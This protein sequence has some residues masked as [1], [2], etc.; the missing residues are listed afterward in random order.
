MPLLCAQPPCLGS[1]LLLNGLLCIVWCR[2]AH[3]RLIDRSINDA[4]RLVTGCLQPTPT[5]N[6]CVL[7]GIQISELRRKRVTLSLARDAQDPKHILYE[8]L[9]Y[10]PYGGHRQLKFRRLFVPAAIDLLN[11]IDVLSTNAAGS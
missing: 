6:L 9:L 5:D 11:D 7:A 1:I 2:S 4:L 3:T 10:P 8:R